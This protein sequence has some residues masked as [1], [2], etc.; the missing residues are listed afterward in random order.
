MTYMKKIFE[1]LKNKV[2]LVITLLIC[3]NLYTCT[4]SCSSSRQVKKVKKELVLKDSVI[5]SKDDSIKVLNK[6]IEVIETEAKGLEKT[7]QIQ[8][9]AINQITEAKKNINIVVRQ[10]K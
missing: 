5:S 7:L 3:L 1:T 9:E 10:K 2:V 4:R 6:R 8:G